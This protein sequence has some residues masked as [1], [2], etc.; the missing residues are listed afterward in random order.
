MSEENDARE[1]VTRLDQLLT[2]EELELAHEFA[3]LAEGAIKRGVPIDRALIAAVKGLTQ[4][5]DFATNA[6]TG[7]REAAGAIAEIA[8][9][10]ARAHGVFS[11]GDVA[12]SAL[13]RLS[14]ALLGLALKPEL[15]ENHLAL[16]ADIMLALAEMSL[17]SVIVGGVRDRTIIQIAMITA[18]QATERKARDNGS[19]VNY[20]KQTRRVLIYRAVEAARATGESDSLERAIES[21]AAWFPNELA[22]MGTARQ[23]DKGRA[24]AAKAVVRHAHKHA[25]DTG[26]G[27]ARSDAPPKLILEQARLAL[28][29]HLGVALD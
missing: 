13:D 11:S 16:A 9:D 26:F 19:K 8:D 27:T 12:F 28:A 24:V 2:R 5:A 3:Q 18:S 15:R 4:G 21:V 17:S 7:P 10:Y 22:A 20:I 6:N 29:W 23:R 1:K 25:R 14:E